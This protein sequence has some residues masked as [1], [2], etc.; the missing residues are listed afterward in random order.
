SGTYSAS[1]SATLSQVVTAKATPIVAL[2]SSGNYVAIGTSVTFTA[3]L[4]GS[5]GA[6]SGT[7][8]FTDTSTGTT[9]CSAVAVASNS[10][11]CVAP[12]LAIGDHAV[13]AA[14]SGSASYLAGSG[15]HVQTMLNTPRTGTAN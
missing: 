13:T 9:L 12:S 8:T 5:A 3:S 1:T 4:S 7:V 11:A 6:V 2:A 14:Y 15:S 10:A